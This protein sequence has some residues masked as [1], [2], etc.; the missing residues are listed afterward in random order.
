[1][2]LYTSSPCCPHHL[3]AHFSIASNNPHT[4]AI[5]RIPHTMAAQITGTRNT[6]IRLGF[7][8]AAAHEIV[9]EQGYDTLTAL[10][11][12]T[13]VTI[14]DMISTIRKPGG[15]IPNPRR[16]ILPPTM[17]LFKK[18]WWLECP[19]CTQHTKRTTSRYGR[20][21]E[22]HYMKQK[23]TTG[24]SVPS[25]AAMDALPIWH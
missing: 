5:K 11:E 4:H 13:D 18:K 25:D 15:T 6:L 23:P 12:L 16:M 1:V 21:Y 14:A 8:A 7:S 9:T 19:T 24:S 2:L 17:V 3:L 20:S 10:S 22:I